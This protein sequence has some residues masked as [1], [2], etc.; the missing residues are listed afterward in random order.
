MDTPIAWNPTIREDSND[1]SISPFTTPSNGVGKFLKYN[2]N[3]KYDKVKN[4]H[5]QMNDN[6]LEIKKILEDE[7]KFDWQRTPFDGIIN[8]ESW[9]NS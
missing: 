8:N 4:D 3:S 2:Q 6:L 9:G 5:G 1:S 7:K